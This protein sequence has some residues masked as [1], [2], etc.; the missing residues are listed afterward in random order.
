MEH[1]KAAFLSR[2]EPFLILLKTPYNLKIVRWSAWIP[3]RSCL[4]QTSSIKHT[5]EQVGTCENVELLNL[6]HLNTGGT[7]FSTVPLLKP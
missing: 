1:R 7:K 4:V 5:T 6:V 3:N 2:S